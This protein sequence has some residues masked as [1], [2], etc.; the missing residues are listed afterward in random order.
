MRYKGRLDNVTNFEKHVGKSGGENL[1]LIPAENEQGGS[2]GAQ[3][4][5]DPVKF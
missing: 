1:G 5:W 4:R 2:V 3:V